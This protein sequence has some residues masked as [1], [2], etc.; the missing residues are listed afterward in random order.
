MINVTASMTGGSAYERSKGKRSA[1]CGR[2]DIFQTDSNQIRSAQISR[3]GRDAEMLHQLPERFVGNRIF[4]KFLEA[5]N[6]IPG[7]PDSL[8]GRPRRRIPCLRR[9]VYQARGGGVGVLL[10][11]FPGKEEAE[12]IGNHQ[13]GPGALQLSGFLPQ[14]GDQLIDR[15]EVLALDARFQSGVPPPEPACRLPD[16]RGYA[17]RRKRR[18]QWPDNNFPQVS[19][20]TKP[21]VPKLHPN[22]AAFP[23]VRSPRSGWAKR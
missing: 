4:Q 16:G 17:V 7:G 2:F 6:P 12:V 21:V 23:E 22:S 5:P 18:Y 19:L 8:S 1:V 3:P 10:P 20:L 13:Q 9:R 15:V 14:L 11:L